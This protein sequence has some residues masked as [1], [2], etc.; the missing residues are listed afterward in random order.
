MTDSP[1]STLAPLEP[2][3]Q[4]ILH[5]EHQIVLYNPTSHALSIR[6][7]ASTTQAASV[8]RRAPPGRCPYCHKSLSGDALNEHAE[9]ELD[10]IAE[11]IY[12][13]PRSRAPNY[14]QL[15]Q[16]ANET[17]SVPSTPATSR[18]STTPTFLQNSSQ[19][20]QD[21]APFRAENMA[22]GYFK[23][24]FQEECRLGMGANGSVYL[25]QVGIFSETTRSMSS[26]LTRTLSTSWTV[27]PLVCLTGATHKDI[28]LTARLTTGRFAMKKIAVGQSH[29]YLLNILREVRRCLSLVL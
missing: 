17:G 15:L 18:R 2:E 21:G 10:D 7:H 11:D 14:F 24:F 23:A 9:G 12:D 28:T 26:K 3:W 8:M 27:I 19:P 25:C 22:E 6:Q 5:G 4:P 29:S 1:F 13:A 20:A 16:T